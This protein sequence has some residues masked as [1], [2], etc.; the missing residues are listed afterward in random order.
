M[1]EDLLERFEL[2]HAH[3][4]PASEVVP[5]IV[6]GERGVE[7]GLGHGPLEGGGCSRKAKGGLPAARA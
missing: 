1:P 7:L 2:A 5:K 4:E 6:E 3:D